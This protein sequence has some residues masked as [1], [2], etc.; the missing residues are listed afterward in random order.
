[1]FVSPAVAGDLV[2]VG[3][4]SGVYYALDRTSGK[5]RWTYDTQV[6]GGPLQF[7]GDP[8]VTEDLVVTGS[9]G[10]KEAFVYAFDL[11]SG[12]RRWQHPVGRGLETDILRRGAAAFGCT[13]GGDLLALDL[14][15]GELRWKI[16]P[17]A[18]ERKGRVP[19]PILVGD[20]LIF[21]SPGGEVHA[22]DPGSGEVRWRRD[23]ASPPH[24]GLAVLAGKLYLGTYDGHVHRLS[25]ATGEVEARIRLEGVPFGVPV[26]AG[27]SLLVLFDRR[28]LA[29]LDPGLTQLRWRQTTWGEWSTERPLPWR[30]G[31]L[32]GNRDGELVA[33]RT[34]D[35]EKLWSHAFEGMLRG[36]GQADGTIYIGTLAGLLY[37]FKPPAAETEAPS[38][39]P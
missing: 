5:V 18:A 38:G 22:V 27:D 14:A 3:S 39:R 13:S 20:R 28:H 19:S 35:G 8:L 15:T 23:L 33:F 12:E 10:G 4:C 30:D 34:A 6:D 29:A 11:A 16:S 17:A 9:D 32:V 1:M 25:L 31:V 2:L 24:T 26:A 37:A 21:A 36:L 7:H